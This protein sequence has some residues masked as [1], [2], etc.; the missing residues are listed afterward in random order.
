MMMRRCEAKENSTR[1][2][3][4]AAGVTGRGH[5]SRTRWHHERI[6]TYVRQTH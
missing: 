2:K 4:A 5:C 3:Q 1:H 6:I